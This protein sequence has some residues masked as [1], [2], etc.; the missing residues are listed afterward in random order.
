MIVGIRIE[1]VGIRKVAKWVLGLRNG[2]AHP[3]KFRKFP[4]SINCVRNEFAQAFQFCKAIRKAKWVCEF[5]AG[6]AKFSQPL[7][8]GIWDFR[9]LAKCSVFPHSEKI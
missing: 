8:N 4:Q 7:L 3:L 6:F 1:T 2:F 5:F 9:N